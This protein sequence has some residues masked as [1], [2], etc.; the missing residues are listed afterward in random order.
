MTL[1]WR[2]VEQEGGQEGR[3]ASESQSGD[4]LIGGR[5]RCPGIDGVWHGGRV[6]LY[7]RDTLRYRVDLEEGGT[8][9]AS[10]QD[11]LDW[12]AR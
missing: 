7:D 2:L 5:V 3:V 12:W 1:F 6:A 8:V 10:R 11:I 4:D 9:S